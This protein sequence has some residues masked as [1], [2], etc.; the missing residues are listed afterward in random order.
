MRTMKR[1]ENSH[2]TR[3]GD[4]V[5]RFEKEHDKC[6]GQQSC[7]GKGTHQALARSL[8]WRVNTSYWKGDKGLECRVHGF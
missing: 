5:E 8:A 1:L 6:R 2:D 7:C 4:F 3:S